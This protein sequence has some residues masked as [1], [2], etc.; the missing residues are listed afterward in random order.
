MKKL[1]RVAAVLSVC[2]SSLAYAQANTPKTDQRQAKQE[3][4]IDQGITSGQLSERETNRLNNQQE[5]INKIEDKAK[6]D[7]VVTKKERARIGQ[8][9]DRASRHIAKQKHDSQKQ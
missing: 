6:S 2:A 1:I 7:D 9:Q 3:Q 4:R 8:A 5:H